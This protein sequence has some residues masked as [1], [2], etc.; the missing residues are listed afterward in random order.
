[1]PADAQAAQRQIGVTAAG[2]VMQT[3]QQ[4]MRIARIQCAHTKMFLG[5]TQAEV[6][7]PA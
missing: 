5:I 7:R 3:L 1:M 6:L 2:F 4:A